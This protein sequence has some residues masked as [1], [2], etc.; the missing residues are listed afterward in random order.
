MVAE[1]KMS[2]T[3]ELF[4]EIEKGAIRPFY[5]FAG[6]EEYLKEEAV[7]KIKKKLID[8][9]QEAFNYYVKQGDEVFSS[10]ISSLLGAC[11]TVPFFSQKKLI[12]VKNAEAACK[13]K[14][15]AEYA[16]DPVPSTCLILTVLKTE[17]ALKK[18]EVMFYSPF[19]PE[20]KA[21]IRKRAAEE[22]KKMTEPAV[23]A[24]LERA[25]TGL[26]LLSKEIEKLA[27]FSGRKESIEEEDVRAV[28]S[29]REAPD[30][31]K[32]VDCVAER[33]KDE[34]L[35]SAGILIR[36]G[37][38]P[39]YLIA[40]MARQFRMIMIAKQLIEKKRSSAEIGAAIGSRSPR[41]TG[42]VMEQGRKFS[43]KELEDNLNRLLD[44]EF[45]IKSGR[46]SEDLAL[47]I[48]VSKL[49]SA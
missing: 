19:V 40:M 6:V 43:Q 23:N 1:T 27:L 25:G 4:S 7:E 22:G 15:I 2:N 21:W 44:T 12:V 16:R 8:P 17:T 32:L 47:E 45:N 35:R 3:K 14:D 29:S 37:I 31:W 30:V 10:G 5:I 13:L 41:Q 34:A 48:L 42:K 26:G 20:A 46:I 36:E 28:I 9:S 11:Q 33:R 39:G 18:Y 38:S 24:L 49:C